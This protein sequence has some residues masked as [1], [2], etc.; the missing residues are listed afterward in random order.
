MVR[1]RPYR[2]LTLAILKASPRNPVAS[3]GFFAAL[4]L[5]L[6]NQVPG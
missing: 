5:V 4:M 1:W 3:F 6:R 2:A